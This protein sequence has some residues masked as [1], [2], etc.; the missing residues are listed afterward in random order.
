VNKPTLSMTIDVEH[1]I[2]LTG[3]A[4][5]HYFDSLKSHNLDLKGLESA[6]KSRFQTP[7]RTRA[8]LREW[9]SLSLTGVTVSHPAKTLSDCL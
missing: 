5:R 6:I 3:T 1:S 8:L 7:E 9:A 4:Q 2:M